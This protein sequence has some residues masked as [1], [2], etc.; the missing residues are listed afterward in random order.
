MS[1]VSGRSSRES[2]TGGRNQGLTLLEVI[3]ALGI[4]AIL[5]ALFVTNVLSNLRHTTVAG[6]RTQAA[7]VLNFLGRL[8]AGGDGDIL[9]ALGSSEEWGYGELGGAFPDIAGGEGFGDADRFRAGITAVSILEFAGAETVQYDISVCFLATEGESCVV[10]TT[11]GAQ[12]PGNQG[13]APL[14]LPGIN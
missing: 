9:P 1:R 6:E 14:P 4:I 11:L 8:A 2:R 5:G 7:Q 10:G 13:L 3:V 12:A